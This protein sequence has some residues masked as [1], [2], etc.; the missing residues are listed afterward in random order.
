MASRRSATG[1]IAL[2]LSTAATQNAALKDNL[3]WT[4]G[5]KQQRGWHIYLPLIA[6]LIETDRDAETTEFA[7]ALARWQ[8]SAGLAPSGVLDQTTLMQMI[9]SWQSRRSTDRSYPTPDQLL[10]APAT[11]FFDATRDAELRQ[12]EKQTYAAYKRLIA[13]AA[14]DPA[15][16]LSTRNGEL[17]AGEK[18]LKIISA[19]RSKEYQ[20]RL[21][22]KSPTSGRAGLAV[23]SPHFTGRALDLYVGGQP[24]ET[25]D[26]NRA[27]QTQ[28]PVYKWLVKN[29]ARFGFVPYFYE[30]WHWEYRAN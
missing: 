8:K 16:K 30:P 1:A 12:V 22:E 17:S 9:Q 4:F 2:D 10:T 29:A 7:A 27:L 18:F 25:K 24:V 28:T 13:A 23:N 5:G 6:H 20:D 26:A 15:L 21:R 11:E 3:E 14:Q 19:F